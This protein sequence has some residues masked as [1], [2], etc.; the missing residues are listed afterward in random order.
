MVVGRVIGHGKEADCHEVRLSLEHEG[1]LW[2]PKPEA[3]STAEEFLASRARFIALRQES[4]WNPW[5]PEERA[6]EV[7]RAMAVINQWGRAEPGHRYLTEEEVEARFAEM[8][9]EHE[10][11]VAAVKRRQ[12]QDRERYDLDREAARLALLEEQAVL[13]RQLEDLGHPLPRPAVPP[14]DQQDLGLGHPRSRHTPPSP[15]GFPV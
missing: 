4:H 8:G 13:G 11:P 15:R 9:R 10:A 2:R 3:T 14:R 7:E 12:E 5:V 6:V 1:L